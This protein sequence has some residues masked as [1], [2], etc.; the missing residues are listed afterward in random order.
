MSDN[1]TVTRPA[2]PSPARRRQARE[3]AAAWY[4]KMRGQRIAHREV[5]AFY[6]WREDACN[7]AAY[8][9]IER[10]AQGVR[11][12]ADDPRLR[13]LA[14]AALDRPRPAKALRSRLGRRPGFWIA[15]LSL[16]AACLAGYVVIGQPFGQTYR[17]AVGERRVVS[18]ADGSSIEL[19]TDSAV[20]VRLTRE[21]RAITLD[22][23][24][25]LFAVAHDAARPFVVTAGD[26]AVRAVGTRFEVYRTGAAVRVTLAEGRVQVTRAHA[27]IPTMMTAG[28]R[29]EV[30]GKT[31]ARPVAVDVAAA[32]GWTNGR[33]TFQDAPLRE[34]VD[35]VNRY[36]RQKVVLGAGAP[37][38]ERVNGVFDAGD[39][40][41]FARGVAASLNLDSAERDDG[42]IELLA[43]TGP[44]KARF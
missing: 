11:A 9:Q 5:T 22:K 25:A 2:E 42:S 6:A 24:Q 20:R 23:G 43:P 4:A 10:L 13:A 29:L 28:T 8:S 37:A 40:G 19:N 39:T 12:H 33:L 17:T 7:D 41:A 21:R 3:E 32:T 15:G 14:Q 44:A 18:L 35:E 16:A 36:S 27:P 1:P 26:T 38:N 30:A 34:A 31:P